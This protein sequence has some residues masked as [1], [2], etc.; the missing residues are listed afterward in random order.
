MKTSIAPWIFLAMLSVFVYGLTYHAENR[1]KPDPAYDFY[2]TTVVKVRLPGTDERHD[3][4]GRFNNILEGQREFVTGKAMGFEEYRLVFK[5]NSPRPALLYLDDEVIEIF[6]VPGDTTLKVSIR[7][8][9]LSYQIDSLDFEGEAAGICKYLRA[10]SDRFHQAQLR[11][12]RNLVADDE[13]SVFAAKLD[14]MAARELGF[15]AEQEIFATLPEWYVDFEKNDI[16]YQ[17]AYL[18]LSNA[19]NRTVPRE[20]LDHLPLNNSSAVFSYYYYLFL[21]TYI[22]QQLGESRPEAS[23]ALIQAQLQLA[24]SLLEAEPHDVFI[25]REIFGQLQQNELPL[26][27]KL[28]REFEDRFYSKKYG[29]FLRRQFKLIQKNQA[30]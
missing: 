3:V 28:L 1:A 2:D 26:V 21:K 23:E 29:R 19:Y 7:A 17:K 22:N 13:F 8:N 20:Y 4:F 18:K 5:V 30:S 16:L 15:L 9:P 24:D 6:L 12:S 11:S 27:R 10:K 14:S 25:T